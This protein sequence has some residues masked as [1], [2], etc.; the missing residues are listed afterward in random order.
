[1]VKLCTKYEQNRVI[2]G[3]IMAISIFDLMTLNM[4]RVAICSG[5]IF[6]QFKISQPMRSWHVT[7]FWCQYI[8]TIWPWETLNIC[9]T[10]YVTCSKYPRSLSE[11]ELSPA[12]LSIIWLIFVPI[13][14]NCDLAFDH[15]PLNFCSRSGVTRSNFVLNLS[16]IEQFAAELL[17]I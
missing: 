17:T 7:I 4:S 3:G 2:L 9:S 14:S 6:T 5:I 13:T 10:S 12:E 11:I 1:M 8:V 15:L 16:E